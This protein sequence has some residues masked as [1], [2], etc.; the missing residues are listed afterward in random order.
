MSVTALH[1][2]SMIIR[3]IKI[4]G[5]RNI[6]REIIEFDRNYNLIY[7]KN[8]SGK[9]SILESIYYCAFCKSFRS[10]D[11]DLVHYHRD[12]CR[13]EAVFEDENRYHKVEYAISKIKGKW[14]KIN[15]KV[16][17]NYTDVISN[18]GIVMFSPD[19]LRIVK[20]GP[21][22]RRNFLNKEI[23]NLSKL[24][25]SDLLEYNKI[26]RQRNALLKNNRPFI[27]FEIWNEQ[28][29]EKS[30]DIIKKRMWYL[31]LLNQLSRDIHFEIS[32]GQENLE[33]KY[34]NHFI[35]SEDGGWD[36]VAMKSKI[37]R[38]LE[39]NFEIDKKRGFTSIGPHTDDIDILINGR[40]S[41]VFASQ[42]Q[43]R[44]AALSVKLAEVDLIKKETGKYPIV[45]LDDI[46]SELDLKRQEQLK[47]VFQ[48]T[49]V[50]ITNAYELG[51][52][53]KIEMN[54]GRIVK[55]R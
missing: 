52:G 14:F 16:A 15:S 40:L 1:H 31:D 10:R 54:H 12:F 29:I 37:Q 4:E 39:K 35:N 50:I 11:I 26:L 2:L 17:R 28:L 49:Q 25:Y 23:S 34:K 7:G 45:L 5:F 27:D 42:G 24:Y 43:Q 3:S 21:A 8:A 51:E 44:T 33:L 18:I 20:D 32:E 22:I 47:K 48:K 41:K 46:L 9:T 36:E 53:Y 30:T 55:N 13:V 38:A 19:D 6:E